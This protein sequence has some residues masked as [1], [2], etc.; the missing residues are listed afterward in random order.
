[1]GGVEVAEGTHTVGDTVLPTVIYAW[2]D[3][4]ALVDTPA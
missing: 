1:M 4:T 3:L 2:R